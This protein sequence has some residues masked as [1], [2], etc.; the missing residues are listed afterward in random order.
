MNRKREEKIEK[1][2]LLGVGSVIL[3]GGLTA[4]TMYKLLKERKK[5]SIINEIIFSNQELMLD[6]LGYHEEVLEEFDERLSN[7][8]DTESSMV[9]LSDIKIEEGKK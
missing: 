9:N 2:N 1:I 7:T 8:K 5:Q 4:Y 6:E 3:S